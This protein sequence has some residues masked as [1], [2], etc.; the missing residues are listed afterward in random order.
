M[1]IVKNGDSVSVHYTGTLDDGS[2]FDTSI[3]K[4]PLKFTLGEGKIIPAFEKAVIGMDSGESKKIKIASDQAYGPYYKE[5]VAILDRKQLP[6]DVSLQIGQQIQLNQPNGQ[7][8]IAKVLDLNDDN[9]TIDANHPLAGQDLNF[10][11]QLVE[12]G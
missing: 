11:I 1:A 9:V 3:D 7:S 4:E 12:I 10:E 6:A 8:V 5:M 2:V